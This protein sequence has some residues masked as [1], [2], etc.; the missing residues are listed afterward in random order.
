MK[1]DLYY[2]G[3]SQDDLGR[4]YETGE[5]IEKRKIASKGEI[6]TYDFDNDIILTTGGK[7]FQLNSKYSDL[8][9]EDILEYD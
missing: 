3:L 7:E 6:V 2:I 5:E 8:G 9:W 1:V 4:N